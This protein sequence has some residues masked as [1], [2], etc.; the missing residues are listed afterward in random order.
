MK[1]FLL[2]VSSLY[3]LITTTIAQTNDY[4][5]QPAFG[6][7]LTMN[8]FITAQRIRS[9]SL[10]QVLDNKQFGKI[11]EMTPGFAITYFKGLTNHLDFAGTLGGSFVN[12]PLVSKPYITNDN[13]FLEAD[14]TGN[15]KMT[16]DQ[17]RLQ[18]YLIAGAGAAMY[19]NYFS[20]YIPLGVGLKINLFE[21]SSFFI[22]SQ[23]RV[24]VTA[25]TNAYHFVHS[26]GIAGNLGKKKEAPVKIV[27]IPEAPPKDSDGDGIIDTKDKCPDVNMMVVP[28]L[29][30]IRM[31]STMRKINAR[32][33]LVS[34]A[35]RAAP[36]LIPIKMVSMTKKIN[37][38]MFLV[39]PVTV[40]ALFRIQTRT[41]SMM[42]KINAR[43]WPAQPITRAVL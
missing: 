31:V 21:G 23:Y 7:S 22:T 30:L 36:Y 11:K 9:G 3:F 8:D 4:V 25:E 43:T 16:T 35:T 27:P 14:A 24:P 12:I 19:R 17:Y 28:F 1:K 33:Y 37:A 32:I 5:R 29:I 15:F 10:S 13:F 20:A 38:G 41:V 6:I 42:K 18:P 2:V 26:F 34:P 39:W 40:A